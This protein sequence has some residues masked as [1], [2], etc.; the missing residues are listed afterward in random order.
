MKKIDM[1]TE[2]VKMIA[3]FELPL[4]RTGLPEGYIKVPKDIEK[5]PISVVRDAYKWAKNLFENQYR[6][7]VRVWR[8]NTPEEWEGLLLYDDLDFEEV[9]ILKDLQHKL[10][11]A[12]TVR[13]SRPSLLKKGYQKKF[14]NELER[15][16]KKTRSRSTSAKAKLAE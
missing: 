14:Q 8:E 15:K 3:L 11:V 12:I 6:D 2:L 5:M 4:R 13:K 10:R 16:S 7:W 9:K 1:I